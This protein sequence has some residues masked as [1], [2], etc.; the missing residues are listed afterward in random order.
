MSELESDQLTVEEFVIYSSPRYYRLIFPQYKPATKNGDLMSALGEMKKWNILTPDSD[1]DKIKLTKKGT[2][3][4][5]LIK[6]LLDVEALHVP[7]T[8]GIFDYRSEP[9]RKAIIE[10]LQFLLAKLDFNEYFRYLSLPI[11]ESEKDESWMELFGQDSEQDPEFDT[12]EGKINL[13]NFLKKRK[14]TIKATNSIQKK[15]F[16]QSSPFK[17]NLS[18]I[19]KFLKKTGLNRPEPLFNHFNAA[20]PPLFSTHDRNFN[21][22]FAE[23]TKI[24]KLFEENVEDFSKDDNSWLADY[25]NL[26]KLPTKWFGFK[27]SEF[28][29]ASKTADTFLNLAIEG[30]K[31][32]ASQFS[33]IENL[34]E[35]KLIHFPINSSES[36][37]IY[38]AD[39]DIFYFFTVP[40]IQC[41]YKILSCEDQ[42]LDFPDVYR[43]SKKRFGKLLSRSYT[44]TEKIKERN[45]AAEE[46][47]EKKKMIEEELKIFKSDLKIQITS[48]SQF[49]ASFFTICSVICQKF[50][51]NFNLN[52]STCLYEKGLI[53]FIYIDSDTILTSFSPGNIEY[54]SELNKVIKKIDESMKEILDIAQ[55]DEKIRFKN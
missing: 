45:L 35:L 27:F 9:G 10:L 40:T 24:K 28:T 52:K 39:I 23:L 47:K 42:F 25:F 20:E 11:F 54:G 51:P 29:F 30:P 36:F 19:K 38:N 6:K 49:S 33:S 31:I 12:E 1:W 37:V 21:V 3:Y 16:K 44:L 48:L 7:Q 32:F 18:L 2:H 46:D 26:L 22:N 14:K 41:N 55:N 4:K 8:N 15:F 34:G 43:T 17:L 50:N 13:D 5:K 53:K